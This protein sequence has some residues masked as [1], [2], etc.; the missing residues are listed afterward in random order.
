MRFHS[1]GSVEKP[2]AGLQ[3]AYIRVFSREIGY[4]KGGKLLAKR[5][6]RLAA[7]FSG[8]RRAFSRD[9]GHRRVQD[10]SQKA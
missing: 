7:G 1:L 8:L 4:S 5:V 3:K 2:L 9:F 6:D 10:G